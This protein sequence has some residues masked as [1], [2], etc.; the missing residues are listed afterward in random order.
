MSNL[1]VVCAT[2]ATSIVCQR[3]FDDVHESGTFAAWQRGQGFRV[4]EWRLDDPSN[5][6]VREWTTFC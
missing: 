4:Y 6:G 2:D 1:W 5:P 3:V